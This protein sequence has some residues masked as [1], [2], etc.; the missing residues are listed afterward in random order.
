LSQDAARGNDY[1]KI[2]I[3]QVMYQIMGRKR[4][5]NH[6]AACCPDAASS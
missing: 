6:I 2:L 1:R 4:G 3:Y 5:D